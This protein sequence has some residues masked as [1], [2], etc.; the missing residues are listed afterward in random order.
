MQIIQL[1]Y[2][3]QETERQGNINLQ[4]YIKWVIV[5]GF[6]KTNHL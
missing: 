1:F 6:P 2:I 5:N 3:K 4:S